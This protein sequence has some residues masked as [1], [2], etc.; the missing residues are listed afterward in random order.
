MVASY[1]RATVST[2]ASEPFY[3]T[4]QQLPGILASL[5][6]DYIYVDRRM[7]QQLPVVGIYFFRDTQE[8]E[9]L[10]PFDPHLLAKF[11]TTAGVDRVYDNGFVQAYH[12]R[13]AWS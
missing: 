9:H 6:L 8:G 2:E 7:T 1:G 13:R 4:P 10:T 3:A 5:S 12:T 11:D